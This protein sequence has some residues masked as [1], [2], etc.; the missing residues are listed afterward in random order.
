MAVTLGGTRLWNIQDDRADI[1]GNV[2]V[3]SIVGDR[4]KDTLL[5]GLESQES[6]NFIGRA[7]GNRISLQSGYSDD[8]NVALAQWVSE[9]EAKV[10]GQQGR[11]YDL[12]H[13]DRDEEY[14]VVIENFSWSRTGGSKYEVQYD[15]V[16]K[17]GI[18][19]MS[20][21]DPAPLSVNPTTTTKIG[22]FEIDGIESIQTTLS[23]KYQVYELAFAPPGGNEY[24]S[25]TGAKRQVII[26]GQVTGD[27]EE[28][29]QFDREMRSLVGIDETVTYKE[30]FPGREFK[31]MVDSYNSARK[32]GL[33]RM[34]DFS[35]EL[36]E[37]RA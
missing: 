30:A 5:T 17:W 1:K 24:A 7:T 4:S 10:N 6:F 36:I 23:Q 33:T 12:V 26:T 27:T 35:I 13:L 2:R 20:L 34:G 21:R 3:D 31:V 19:I 8:P 25:D 32:A 18:G 14:N 28:R 11:G 16:L 37:G 15:I 29:N 22:G 9:M